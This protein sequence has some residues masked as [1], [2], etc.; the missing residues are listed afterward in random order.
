MLKARLLLRNDL[1]ANW[2]AH[3]PILLK[4]EV[5][6][7]TDTLRMKVGDGATAWSSLPYTPAAQVGTTLPTIAA[8]GT[9]VLSGTTLYGYQNGEWTA[10]EMKADN[11]SLEIVGGALSILGW[12]RTYTKQDGTIQIVDESHPWIAGL[13]PRSLADGTLGWFEPSATT[14]EGLATE[15]ATLKE[16]KLDKEGGAITGILTLADGSKAASEA[17]VDAKIAASDHLKRSIVEELPAVDKA[18]ALTIYMIHDDAATNDTYREYMLIEGALAQIGDTS[19]DLTN[20][21]Q[22]EEGKTLVATTLVDKL[23]NLPAITSIGAGL[24]LTEGVLATTQT[25]QSSDEITVETN[26]TLSLNQVSVEKLYVP[27]T[28]ELI[29]NGGTATTSTSL[30][31]EDTLV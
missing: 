1:A 29:L 21:V 3:N 31:G 7:E 30:V 18:D 8:E 5:G 14:V 17:I 22:K 11:S 20:Y 19:V 25:L 2:L 9:L 15:I 12:G 26:N 16:T 27:D 6:I 13:Q 23:T 4:G 24:S 28:T 10:I